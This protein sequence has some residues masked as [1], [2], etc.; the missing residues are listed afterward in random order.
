MRKKAAAETETD[1]QVIDG[2]DI[3]IRISLQRY[4]PG[5]RRYREIPGTSIRIRFS[6]AKAID[7]FTKKLRESIPGLL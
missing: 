3:N 2:S 6:N 4:V 1:G 5:G 7:N